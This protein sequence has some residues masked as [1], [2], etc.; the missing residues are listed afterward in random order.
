M[1]FLFIFTMNY[2]IFNQPIEQEVPL[3]ISTLW[4]P[5]LLEDVFTTFLHPM[6]DDHYSY[7]LLILI[8]VIV[9]GYTNHNENLGSSGESVAS[10]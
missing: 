4:I 3:L 10:R 9:N 6:E 1:E 2:I 5:Q 8:S 7:P